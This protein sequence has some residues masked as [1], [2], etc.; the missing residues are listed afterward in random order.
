MANELKSSATTPSGPQNV[1]ITE[2]SSVN[3]TV[4]APP[5]SGNIWFSYS[6]GSG[7]FILNV[8]FNGQNF[9][10]VPQGQ[11]QLS[12]LTTPLNLTVQGSGS[13]KLAWI[14]G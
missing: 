10:N 6:V 3:T 8:N 11:Y 13:A 12:G 5:S 2:G 14:A 4:Q 9:P 1:V 7:S